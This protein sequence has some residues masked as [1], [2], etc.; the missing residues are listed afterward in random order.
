MLTPTAKDNLDCP[1]MQKWAGAREL[2]RLLAG[3]RLMTT[4]TARD[5][6]SGKASARTMARNSRLLNEQLTADGVT[7]PLDLLAIYEWV[8]GFPPHWLPTAGAPTGT[9]LC[10][11]SGRQSS[12]RSSPRKRS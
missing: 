4:P 7:D 12:K 9:R 10:R 1:S 5:W 2:K 8:M 6:R 11:R 3:A